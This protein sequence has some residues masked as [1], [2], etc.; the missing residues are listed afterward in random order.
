VSDRSFRRL[1]DAQLDRLTDDE[2]IAYLRDA[3]AHEDVEAA[4]LALQMLV[5]GYIDT[6][7]YRVALNLRDSPDH[8][9]EEITGRVVV[10]AITSAFRGE[11]V[12]EFR[13]FM[14]RII[15]RRIADYLRT[16]RVREVPL[17]EEH[18]D[19]PDVRG[20]TVEA[21][22]E[23]GEVL[24]QAL[25]DQ[26]LAELSEV[27][28][29]VVEL[30]VF[31]AASAKETAEVVTRHFPDLQPPMGENNVHQIGSRFRRRMRDLLERDTG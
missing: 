24:V 27:H 28:R 14:N 17:A 5:Y 7:A 22:D 25:I 8:V 1:N 19:E 15:E 10:S 26:A 16:K 2:L 31:C 9:V 11:S 23:T 6:V 13:S 21:P 4:T 30:H 20:A 3:R 18:Q 29:A 12:G